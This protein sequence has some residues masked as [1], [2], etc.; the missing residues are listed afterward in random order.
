MGVFSTN[1]HHH[2]IAVEYLKIFTSRLAE[3]RVDVNSVTS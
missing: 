2:K 1:H 3:Q